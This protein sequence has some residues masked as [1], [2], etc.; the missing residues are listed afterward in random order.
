MSI[1]N[2]MYQIELDNLPISI[3]NERA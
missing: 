1:S 3:G 2:N